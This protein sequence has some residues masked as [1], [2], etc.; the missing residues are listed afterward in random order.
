MSK[1]KHPFYQLVE[2]VHRVKL[3]LLLKLFVE[4]FLPDKNQRDYFILV[5]FYFTHFPNASF[6]VIPVLP[7]YVI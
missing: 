4:F 2:I 5:G 6:V 7:A 3:L 1:L